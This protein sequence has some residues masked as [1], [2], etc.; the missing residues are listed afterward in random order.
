MIVMTK[1]SMYNSYVTMMK[2]GGHFGEVLVLPD[3]R[4][5]NSIPKS[6]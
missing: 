2:G 6:V 1:D 4:R 3:C 5:G